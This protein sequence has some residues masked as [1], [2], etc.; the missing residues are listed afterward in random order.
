MSA[1]L[2]HLLAIVQTDPSFAV[3]QLAPAGL[4]D[5]L[6]GGDFVGAFVVDHTGDFVPCA[7]AGSDVKLVDGHLVLRDCGLGGCSRFRQRLELNP[8]AVF[9]RGELTVKVE[10]ILRFDGTVRGGQ[11]IC[12]NAS[13]AD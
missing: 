2:S 13:P 1:L 11:Y 7:C 5:G 12:A 8:T 6:D 10:C 4:A 9:H 3:C